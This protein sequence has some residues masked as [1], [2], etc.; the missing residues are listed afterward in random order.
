MIDAGRKRKYEGERLS[1]RIVFYVTES[2]RKELESAS[3]G[4]ISTYTREKVFGDAKPSLKKVPAI[5][6]SEIKAALLE[7]LE[8]RDSQRNAHMV[9]LSSDLNEKLEK[10]SQSIGF[11]EPADFIEEV[12]RVMLRD[13]VQLR[14]LVLGKTLLELEAALG[15]TPDL[16]EPRSKRTRKV[17]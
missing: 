16:E 1:E 6:Q 13:P 14:E 4:D 2:Q 9:E 17:A 10:V 8:E 3:G 7:A 11:A 15:I 5:K 12:L